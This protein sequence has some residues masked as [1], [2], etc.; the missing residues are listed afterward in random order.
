MMQ[1]CDVQLC[2]HTTD[3]PWKSPAPRAARTMLHLAMENVNYRC[4]S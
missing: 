1:S 2:W 3:L 4:L